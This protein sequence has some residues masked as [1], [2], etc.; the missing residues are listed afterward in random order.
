MHLFRQYPK[1]LLL[2]AS[3]I[4]AYV[5]YQTGMLS[6]IHEIDHGT[7][8]YVSAFI[9][10]VLFTFGFTAPL[11][12]GIFVEIA[13]ATNPFLASLLG[14][15][16]SVIADLFIFQM[17]RFDLFSSEINRLK[18]TRFVVFLH[19]ALHHESISERVRSYLLW[20]FA[21]IIIASP[22]PDEFGV[23][24][25][26]AFSDIKKSTFLVLSL[27]LNAVG[28]FVILETARLLGN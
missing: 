13:H 26:S 23:S 28:I 8:E 24:L 5:L 12:V 16:G 27:C 4:G 14:G 15:I 6:W 21:G 2:C 25:V 9:A 10:G 17:I 7:G 18:T 11:G 20:I 19:R 1:L 22:L 3:T